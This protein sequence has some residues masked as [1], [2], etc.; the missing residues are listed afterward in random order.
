MASYDIVRTKMENNTN[1]MNR[2]INITP[3]EYDFFA[4]MY[5]NTGLKQAT[6]VTFFLSTFLGLMLMFGIIWYERNGNHRYRTVINQLFSTLSWIVVWYTLLV[7]IPD[8]IRYLTGPLNETYCDVHNFLKNFLFAAAML[9]L[10][11]IALLRHAFI[12]KL[13][14]FAVI[15]DDL[16]AT[17][18]N[19]CILCASLWTATVKRMSVGKMPLQYF[20][21]A[22]INPNHE[23][24]I[25]KPP[26]S[27]GTNHEDVSVG[28]QMMPGKFNATKIIVCVTFVLH[29]YVFTKIFLFQRKT[30]QKTKTIK[31]GSV[32]PLGTTGQHQASSG[33]NVFR[34]SES[35]HLAKSMIDFT[36]QILSLI[37]I[38]FVG[39]VEL[40]MS[41]LD[42]IELNEYENR[43]Y[44]YFLQIMGQFVA[45]LGISSVYYARNSALRKA[46][47]RRIKNQCN[48]QT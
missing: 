27:N 13:S 42:P 39:I 21:C 16:I 34:R 32:E 22:G 5:S 19:I 24:I 47:W 3:I 38:V 36:T 25:F 28:Y 4:E 9:A 31:L 8:G 1:D 6:V 15:N 7:Y 2:T 17:F 23:A 44:P 29:V 45:I 41:R 43:W 18:L 10:D 12:F 48:A 40:I 14:N 26:A 30:E 20:M 11:C 35:I 37:Y 33:S 46:I